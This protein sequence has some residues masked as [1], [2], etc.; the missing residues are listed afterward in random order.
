MWFFVFT[1]LFSGGLIPFFLVVR[2][3]GLI[4]SFWSMIIP[5]ALP[6]YFVVIMMNFF[7]QLPKELYESA[8]IDGASH[9]T[10]LFRIFVPLSMPS[11]ATLLLFTAVGHW[12]DWF[13]AMIF[14]NNPDKWPLQTYLR[15]AMIQLDY[16]RL[17]LHELQLLKKLSNRTLNSAQIIITILPILCVYPFIQKYFTKGIILGSIKE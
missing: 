6:V 5:S 13:T 8:M 10:I 7:R 2:S 17:T 3:L 15:Q 4:D 9:W 1:L 11:I 12:N 14:I 16:T